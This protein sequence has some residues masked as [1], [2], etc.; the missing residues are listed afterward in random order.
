M[1]GVAAPCLAQV[2]DFAESELKELQYE[3]T[4]AE[5]IVS[6]VVRHHAPSAWHFPLPV[7]LLCVGWFELV[8]RL[9]VMHATCG[10]CRCC[11]VVA[12]LGRHGVPLQD[13]EL[14]DLQVQ[15]A[16]EE[17][18]IAELTQAHGDDDLIQR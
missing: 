11:V 16:K 12:S 13:Q 8:P 3:M 2:V 5:D 7:G 15:C 9:N 17:A 18:V 14:D 6:T 1:R 4:H 10:S